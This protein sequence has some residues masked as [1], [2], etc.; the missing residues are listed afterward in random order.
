MEGNI[1]GIVGIFIAIVIM[2]AIGTQILGNTGFDC[3]GL[4]G[5]PTTGTDAE[6]KANS[7]GWAASCFE[8]SDQSQSGY[9]L[10]VIII[11]VVAA[12]GMLFVVRMLQ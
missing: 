1:M 7:V 2:L 10:L 8:V 4:E 3:K 11:I 12:V 9:N 6:K 5:Y